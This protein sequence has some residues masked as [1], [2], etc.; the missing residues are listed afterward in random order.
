MSVAAGILVEIKNA[1]AEMP[2]GRHFL[3][4]DICKNQIAQII[5]F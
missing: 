5:A 4:T 3:V 1:I 2:T